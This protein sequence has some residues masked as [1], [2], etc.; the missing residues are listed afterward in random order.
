MKSFI[1]SPSIPYFSAAGL[2]SDMEIFFY[3]V[4]FHIG[5]ALITSLILYLIVYYLLKRKS[6]RVIR[7][8]IFT[9]MG[10][11]MGL[12]IVG[13][14]YFCVPKSDLPSEQQTIDYY[15]MA[16]I[17]SSVYLPIISS[18]IFGIAYII[19]QKREE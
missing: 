18:L 15:G 9:E 8:L 14:L 3:I 19:K 12:V 2:P 5:I 6:C 11:L 4:C 7:M 13:V 1:L 16:I 17:W 10:A